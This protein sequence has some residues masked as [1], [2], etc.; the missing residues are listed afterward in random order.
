MKVRTGQGGLEGGLDR[1]F[2]PDNALEAVIERR[3]RG[4]TA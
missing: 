4:V 1:G 2:N 3:V